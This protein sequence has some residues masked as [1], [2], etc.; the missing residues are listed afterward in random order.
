MASGSP[1]DVQREERWP[2]PPNVDGVGVPHAQRGVRRGER[3][4]DDSDYEDTETFFRRN[5]QPVAKPASSS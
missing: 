4:E 1:L 3:P 2:T 5:F